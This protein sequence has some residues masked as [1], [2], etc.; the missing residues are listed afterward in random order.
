MPTRAE[1]IGQILSMILGPG[2]AIAGCLVG[3]GG[4]VASQ[5][6]TKTKEEGP[7]AEGAAAPPA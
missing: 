2:A 4:Q 5:I 1:A 3:P 7:P 6:E